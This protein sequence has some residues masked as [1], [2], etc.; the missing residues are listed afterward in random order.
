MAAVEGLHFRK[1]YTLEEE[2]QNEEKKINEAE[3]RSR[4]ILLATNLAS[5][6]ISKLF[7]LSIKAGNLSD[8]SMLT[9][10]RVATCNI[11]DVISLVN[12]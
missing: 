7:G 3:D 1:V 8:A 6:T 2:G 5:L 10:E 11:K 4:N 9:G 12:A